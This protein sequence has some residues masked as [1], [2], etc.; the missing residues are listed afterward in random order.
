MFA[1]AQPIWGWVKRA[2]GVFGRAVAKRFLKTAAVKGALAVAPQ[3][4]ATAGEVEIVKAVAKKGQGGAYRFTVT[5]RHA[6]TGWD[7]YAD[8]WEVLAPDGKVLGTRVLY[9]PHVNEQPFTR[10]LTGVRVPVC[11]SRVSIRAHDKVHGTGPR[12]LAVDLP[13]R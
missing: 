5:L 13:G 12:P 11:V 10:S 9:H 7:H 2:S 1:A 3:S 4:A 6:D 8:A